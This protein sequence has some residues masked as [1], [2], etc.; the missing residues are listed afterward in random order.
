MAYFY[1]LPAQAVADSNRVA[2]DVAKA[3][4]GDAGASAVAVAAMISIFAALN[5]S[6]LSGARVPYAM[7]RDGY[8][9]AALGRVHPH[10]RSPHISI[11]A[12]SAWSALLVL[13][14][15][16]EQL[17]TY[18]IFSSWILYGM[19]AATVFVLRRKRPDLVRPHRTIGYPVVP[20]LLRGRRGVIG[21]HDPE[22]FPAGIADGAGT[23]RSGDSVL[24]DLEKIP[25]FST[26]PFLRHYRCDCQ[27]GNPA[28]KQAPVPTEIPN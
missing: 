6:I 18:V 1:V 8:F 16:Y 23:H 21:G 19:A 24:L 26:K 4:L 10:Y 7:A 11:L 27:A 5:G 13:S 3:F 9:F 28:S 15:S 12:L 2:S 17:F 20:L 14:G 25:G 22:G